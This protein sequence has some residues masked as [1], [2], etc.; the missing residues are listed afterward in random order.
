MKCSN[1]CN[2]STTIEMAIRMQV[3]L[4][5]CSQLTEEDFKI[6]LKFETAFLTSCLTLYCPDQS[7]QSVL[8]KAAS[9]NVANH[10]HKPQSTITFSMH[11][12][13]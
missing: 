6:S 1:E 10:D 13:P 2:D 7:Q 3:K 5:N 11:N 4:D 12:P 8:F 9:S